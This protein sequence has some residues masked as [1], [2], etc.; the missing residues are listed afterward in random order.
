MKKREWILM[1]PPTNYEIRCDLCNGT[2]ITWSEYKDRIWCY[3]CE[4]DT[5]GTPNCLNG[6]VPITVA[7]L[8]NC[9]PDELH[10]KTNK[11]KI[12]EREEMLTLDEY[13]EF[14]KKELGGF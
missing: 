10:I 3:D 14:I 13:N 12:A 9:P 2:N 11:V 1:A 6:P 5:K 8:L 4:K 7:R